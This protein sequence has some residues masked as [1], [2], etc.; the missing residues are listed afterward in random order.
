MEQRGGLRVVVANGERVKSKGLCR[1]VPLKV[2]Q[3]C[4]L[5]DLYILPLN[6][7]DVVLGVN[8]LQT[9][10]SI[11]WD[12]KTMKMAFVSNGERVDFSGIRTPP[13]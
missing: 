13:R 9:L 2:N 1:Q 10:G 11:L 6:E 4:F 7:F 12:F 5:V 8:W 3:H